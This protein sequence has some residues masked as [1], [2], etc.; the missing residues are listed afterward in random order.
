MRPMRWATTS[1][2]GAGMLFGGTLGRASAGPTAIFTCTLGAAIDAAGPAATI[3]GQGSC[4][5]LAGRLH[6]IV[7]TGQG[8]GGAVTCLPAVPIIRLPAMRVQLDLSDQFGLTHQLISQTWSELVGSPGL[9]GAPVYAAVVHNSAGAIGGLVTG[10]SISAAACAG[11][12]HTQ[13]PFV[14]AFTT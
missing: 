5:D 10:L 1:V 13:G 6:P 9:T 4:L 2:V 8:I 14:L 7:F 3:S 11:P 12:T